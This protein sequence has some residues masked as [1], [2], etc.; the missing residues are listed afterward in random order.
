MNLDTITNVITT[1][2]APS[3]RCFFVKFLF[4]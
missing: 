3:N 2:Q 1:K 4:S